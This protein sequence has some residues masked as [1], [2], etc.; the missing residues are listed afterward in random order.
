MY[1]SEVL[2]Q[3]R[4]FP[5][6]VLMRPDFENELPVNLLNRLR[7]RNWPLVRQVCKVNEVQIIKEIWILKLASAKKMHEALRRYAIS[8]SQVKK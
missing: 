6:I 4:Y 2:F 3:V 8:L 7:N 1:E 5:K